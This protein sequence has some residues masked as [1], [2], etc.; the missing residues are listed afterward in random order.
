ML[1]S[2]KRGLTKLDFILGKH[3]KLGTLAEEEKREQVGI[4][5]KEGPPPPFPP[6]WEPH[7]CERKK[8]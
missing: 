3:I 7:V 1:Q 5:S 6:V 2:H 4:F 8:L